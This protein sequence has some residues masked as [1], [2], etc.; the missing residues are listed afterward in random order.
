MVRLVFSVIGCALV[1]ASIADVHAQQTAPLSKREIAVR[2]KAEHLKPGAHISVIRLHE[3]EEFGN[4]VSSEQQSFTFYD[5]DQKANVVLHYADVKKIKDGYGGY[6]SIHHRHVDP[7][8]RLIGVIVGAGI[9]I[10]LIVAV[11]V[12]Q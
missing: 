2:H 6:N 9:I 3:P 7:T 4:F 5:V 8:K 10:G 1:L 11:A 12:S